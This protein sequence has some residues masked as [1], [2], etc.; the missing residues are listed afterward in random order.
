MLHAHKRARK[1]KAYKKSKQV[2]KFNKLYDKNKLDLSRAMASMNSWIAH[3]SHC[4]SYNLQQKIIKSAKFIYTDSTCQ[5]IN[6]QLHDLTDS[7]FFDDGFILAT[8]YVK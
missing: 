3:S 4:N 5:N 8:K 2:R 1:N 6:N 7:K